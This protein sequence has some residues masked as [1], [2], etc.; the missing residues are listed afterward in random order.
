[1]NIEI[2]VFNDPWMDSGVENFYRILSELESCEVELTKNSMVLRIKDIQE[3]VKELTSIVIH[4]RQNL[5]VIEEDKK[6]RIKKEV[7]KDH[8]IIQEEKKVGGKV[9]LKE[10]IYKPEKTAEIIS[11]VFDLKEGKNT[12]ILCGRKYNKS[13]K[14]LQQANYPFVTKIASLSGVR[15]YKGDGVL[16]LKEY[17]DNLCPL[18]YFIGILEWTDEAL[19]YRTFPGEKSY[20]FMPYFD[21]LKDLHEFK[22]LCIN[23]G[24]LNNAER[25]SNIKVNPKAQDVE[26]TPGEYSTL[27]CFYEKFVENA[28][29]EIIASNWAVLHIPF[30]A[31][32]NVKIDFLNIDEG[33]LGVIKELKESGEL[34]RIYSDLMRK[35]YF[36]SQNKNTTDWDTTREIQ[37]NLSKYFLLDD[38]RKFTNSLLPRK[39]G[40]VFFSSEVRQNL[41]ELIFE[42]RWKKMSVEKDKLDAVRNVGRIVAKISENNASPIYKLDKVRTINEF[43]SV[44]R[45]I[46]RK[47]PSLNEEKLKKI[48]PT[49]LDEVIQLTKEI[50]ERN[51]DGWREV[52]DLIVVYASM[53][54]SLDKL[55]KRSEGGEGDEGY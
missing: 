46:S 38:F 16:S 27:L 24:I 1:M 25:Y 31:V 49:A 44:L 6:T 19:I 7:K 13:I 42:W 15:S 41:E 26:N 39:G 53:Y 20:L 12:C 43:W 8:V 21:N 50:V 35:M 37:E 54:Y 52:R 30:G 5:I 22:K 29:D 17:Y 18:C 45:E 23:A 32:K 2:N 55:G 33:I 47:L 14:K 48:K 10:E 51:K 36:F 40:Y 11:S 3:F 34:E 9:A 28:T 4:K